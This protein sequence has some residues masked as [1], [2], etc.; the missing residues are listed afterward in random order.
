MRESCKACLGSDTAAK[1]MKSKG[2]RV[3]GL[4]RDVLHVL[5]HAKQPIGAYDLFDKLNSA[6]KASAPP[7]IYR[8]LDFLVEQGLAHKL[9]SLSAYA[10]CCAAPR[11]HQAFFLICQSCGDVCELEGQ[12]IDPA[13]LNGFLVEDMVV[14]AKGICRSCQALS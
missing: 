1:A 7:A 9:Q 14:E 3:T 13:M 10:A 11:P 2:I 4:R 12:P 8:V 5:H 6:G